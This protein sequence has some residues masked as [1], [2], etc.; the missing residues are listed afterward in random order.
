MDLDVAKV[1]TKHPSLLHR[2]PDVL[3]A[4]ITA[5]E[6]MGL[7]AGK[8]VRLF[9]A[10][11]N[12]TEDRLRRTLTFLAASGLDGVRVINVFPTVSSYSVETKLRPIVQFVTVE[13]RRHHGVASRWF[14]RSEE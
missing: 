7:C 13:I 12:R 2:P 10:V 1:L 9:P 6:Q 8:V 11:V 5:L 3:R 14:I 4:K